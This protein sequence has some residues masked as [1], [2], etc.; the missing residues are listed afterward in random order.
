MCRPNESSNR[1]RTT[2]QRALTFCP[3]DG[4][5]TLPESGDVGRLEH[6]LKLGARQRAVVLVVGPQLPR[7]GVH[8][9]NLYVKFTKDDS[10]VSVSTVNTT[11]TRIPEI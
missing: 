7:D 5:R 8:W 1:K 4:P 3:S 11:Y 9:E 2:P 6:E 10:I